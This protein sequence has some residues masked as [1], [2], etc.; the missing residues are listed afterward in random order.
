MHPAG[1][2]PGSGGA[3]PGRGRA[4]AAVAGILPRCCA[5][6]GV[7]FPGLSRPGVN[8]FFFP[9][10][11]R[12]FRI[13][14]VT[15]TAGA[16]PTR[17]RPWFAWW[18][19]PAPFLFSSRPPSARWWSTSIT[20]RERPSRLRL[21]RPVRTVPAVIDRAGQMRCQRARVLT[22][23]AACAALGPR[24][25]GGTVC[26]TIRRGRGTGHG[27]GRWRL[28]PPDAGRLL[29]A[30]GDSDA[31]RSRAADVLRFRCGSGG[32]GRVAGVS[33][34]A[35]VSRPGDAAPVSLEAVSY[36]Y[37]GRTSRAGGGI[38]GA[39]SRARCWAGVPTRPEKTTGAWSRPACAVTTVGA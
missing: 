38:A 20:G 10:C 5:W 2:R 8:L 4:A 35:G 21:K 6:A 31:E 9:G 24:P 18:P 33:Q 37:A 23:R 34:G 22:P 30:P 29:W 17:R 26:W 25:A 13:G 1:R 39:G 27:L 14:P 15:S 16:L 19:S 12:L 7:A 36:G 11:Q 32:P 28:T 3:D